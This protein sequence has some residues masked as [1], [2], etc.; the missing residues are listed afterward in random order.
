MNDAAKR[1]RE[2]DAADDERRGGALAGG[3]SMGSD[4]F[5]V[6]LREAVKTGISDELPKALSS[7]EGSVVGKVAALVNPIRKKVD[8]HDA[9]I[10]GL[11]ERVVECKN[12]IN[13]LKSEVASVRKLI[14]VSDASPLASR[15]AATRD[16]TEFDKTLVRI[17]ANAIV[18]LSAVD[19]L[20]TRLFAEAS[21]DRAT[22]KL[23]G[24]SEGKNFRLSFT[25]DDTATAG[26]RA[27]KF[28]SNLRTDD[29]WKV[30]EVTRPTGGNE[31]IYMQADQSEI[32]VRKARNVG[33]LA[34]L[35]T[36]DKPSVKPYKSK[37]DGTVS[38]QWQLLAT[39]EG[40]SI[41]WEEA[42]STAGLGTENIAAAFN[43]WVRSRRG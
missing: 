28:L 12:D 41:K 7:L 38:W 37:R 23:Q 24:P 32:A 8:Q 27:A 17:N 1:A 42:A 20:I 34:Q 13:S 29:G 26:R 40:D 3:P 21:M 19:S 4:D 6:Q 22:A 15:P 5:E 11:G 35:I 30:L 9:A 16:P 2:N 43:S 36:E 10:S 25:G 18:G 31:R 14:A 33:K 39:I